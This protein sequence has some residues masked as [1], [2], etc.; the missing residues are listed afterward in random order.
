MYSD[1]TKNGSFQSITKTD[2]KI[3][4]NLKKNLFITSTPYQFIAAF[5]LCK[6]LYASDAFE[7]IIYFSKSDKTNYDITE[8]IAEF[9]GKII[10]FETQNWSNL[11]KNLQQESF[12]RFFFFQ[13]NSIY[14]K[15]LAYFLKKKGTI[16]CLGPD[17]TKPYGLFNKKHE[18][19]SMFKDTFADY[20]LLA[21]Q[22]LKLPK[23][24]WSKYYKYG[25]TPLLDEVW[26]QYPDLFN[27]KKN[28]T[29]GKIIKMPE[30]TSQRLEILAVVFGFN[31]DLL[32]EKQNVILYFNQPFIT[33]ALINKEFEILSLIA[34][35]F[36]QK[37]INIKLHPA[38]NH[39]VKDR[40]SNISYI[41]TIND[42]MPAEFYLA[43][44]TDSIIVSGWSAA[45]M[46]DFMQ[47]NNN[48]FY[49]YPM[50]KKT[51]DKTLSQISFIGFPH[52]QMVDTVEQLLWK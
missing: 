30:L 50:Y 23:L 17:G 22:K 4:T 45:I 41:N 21:K 16:I 40:M 31:N 14:N 20:K 37:K 42:K 35:R 27:S 46:H 3:M 19:L 43:M 11:V 12:D 6:E 5:N 33:E 51:N 49:L 8:S 44:V 24:V 10:R 9:N 18:L 26:L 1:R 15:Y 2:Q 38:T 36:P 29:K 32:L 25:A 39:K 34:K 28:K 52:I 13:E 48:S 47:Q 7:N